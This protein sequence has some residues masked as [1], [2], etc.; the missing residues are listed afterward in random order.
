[1]FETFGFETLTAPQAAVWFALAIGVV[2]GALAQIT[3]FCFRRALVGDDARAAAGVWLTAL[4]VA[5]AGTQG[6]VAYG[7]ISFGEHR[8]MAGDLPVL[9]II[10]GG[11]LFGAGMVLTRGCV[12]WLTVLTGSGN[13]RALMV[14]VV[15]AITAHATLK[16]VLAPL[17]TT[18][19]SVTLPLQNA[20]LPGNAL[21]WAALIAVLALGFALRSGNRKRTLVV[22]ALIVGKVL[23]IT[24]FSALAVK[25][26]FPLP[27]GMGYREL[28]VTSCVAGLG[29]TVALFVCGQAFV[30]PSLQA[31]AKMGAVFSVA[32]AAVAYAAKMVLSVSATTSTAE[33]T[34]VGDGVSVEEQA[35]EAMTAAQVTVQEALDAAAKNSEQPTR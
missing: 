9:A 1:M 17:R 21:V 23:G 27:K 15:F 32:A 5:V 16:G 24:G 2:F 20:A 30:D 6:A 31:A 8:F 12:S 19:G 33:P 4:A 14:L 26:G 11:L 35:L 34:S 7:L 25:L 13:L 18:L 10:A 29:L 3:R 28:V 22:A